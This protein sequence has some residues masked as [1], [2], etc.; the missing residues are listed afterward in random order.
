MR[1]A[2]L[3]PTALL[4]LLAACGSVP[5]AP[6]PSPCP[7]AMQTLDRLYLGRAR[8][9]G[10]AEVSDEELR[11]FLA[12]VVTPRFPQ[13]LTWLPAQGQWREADGRIVAERSVVLELVHEGSA[14]ERTRVAEIADA[15]RQRFQQE[16]VLRLTHLACVTFPG[17]AP[18]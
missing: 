12:D 9:G 11:R 2:L 7:V 4:L 6:T 10:G 14:A 3:L 13:G 18:G 5:P 1:T 8:P 15:W 16:A 17:A